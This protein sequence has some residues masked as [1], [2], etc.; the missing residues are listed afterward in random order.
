[1]QN[2]FLNAQRVYHHVVAAVEL[3]KVDAAKGC[4]ILVLVTAVNL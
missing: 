4:R 3:D 2:I 1:M